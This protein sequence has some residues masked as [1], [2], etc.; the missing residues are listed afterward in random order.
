MQTQ[1]LGSVDTQ[2][3]QHETDHHICSNYFQ[4]FNKKQQNTCHYLCVHIMAHLLSKSDLNNIWINTD[5]QTEWSIKL[6]FLPKNH[7]FPFSSSTCMFPLKADV[8][9]SER[10]LFKHKTLLLSLWFK[11]NE[12]AAVAGTYRLFNAPVVRTQSAQDYVWLKL[13]VVFKC[14]CLRESETHRD[15]GIY[16]SDNQLSHFIGFQCDVKSHKSHIT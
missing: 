12:T 5:Y 3:H 11:G 14:V 6:R 2:W 16:A 13:L 1:T 9:D 4:L 7:T 8:T 15:R 10:D